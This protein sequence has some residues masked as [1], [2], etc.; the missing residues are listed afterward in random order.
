[1]SKFGFITDWYQT[2]CPPLFAGVAFYAMRAVFPALSAIVST[3][4]LLGEL[5]SN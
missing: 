2:M 5:V 3:Y 1:M 4:A